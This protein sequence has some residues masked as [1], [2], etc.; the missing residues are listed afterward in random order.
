[1]SVGFL[2]ILLT[3][4]EQTA[5]GERWTWDARLQRVH[6]GSQRVCHHTKTGVA[7]KQASKARAEELRGAEQCDVP[8]P[9]PAAD[10]EKLGS[11]AATCKSFVSIGVWSE[12]RAN[13]AGVFAFDMCARDKA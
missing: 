5:H 4:Y 8:G 1:M 7:R 6:V 10:P 11:D 12:R 13:S 3:L 2:T 9:D